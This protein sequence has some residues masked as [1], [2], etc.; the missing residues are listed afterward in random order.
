LRRTITIFIP[1]AALLALAAPAGGATGWSSPRTVGSAETG[2][3]NPTVAIDAAG[4]AVVAWERHSDDFNAI[5]VAAE[6]GPGAFGET[7]TLSNGGETDVRL[8]GVAA[9][10]AGDAVV[11]WCSRVGGN[12][13]VRAAERPANGDFGAAQTLSTAPAQTCGRLAINAKGDAAV[14]W[15]GYGQPRIAVRSSGG[16]FGAEQSVSGPGAAYPTAVAIDGTGKAGL[17]WA[18]PIGG[19][20]SVRLVSARRSAT[21]AITAGSYVSPTYARAGAGSLDYDLTPDGSAAASWVISDGQ[22]ASPTQ[23]AVSGS[24]DPGLGAAHSLGAGDASA[25]SDRLL[26]LQ[27]LAG[28]TALFARSDS[29]DEDG[30]R[31][32]SLTLAAGGGAGTATAGWGAD[33]AVGRGASGTAAATWR[34]ATTPEPLPGESCGLPVGAEVVASAYSPATG[35]AAP[36]AISDPRYPASIPRASRGD[37]LAVAWTCFDGRRDRIQV[38]SYGN[39]PGEP[40]WC[41]PEDLDPPKVKVKTSRFP[42]RWRSSSRPSPRA[43][44]QEQCSVT[45]GLLMFSRGHRAAKLGVSEQVLKPGKAKRLTFPELGRGGRRLVAR[46]VKRRSNVRLV[47]RLRFDDLASNSVLKTA[48]VRLLP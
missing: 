39:G 10:D 47:Y 15:S 34:K 4:R 26:S 21:G 20:G 13:V 27:A 37:R 23:M 5:R 18:S 24:V 30:C 41:G 43:T 48:R 46:A 38:A 25:A 9:D 29:L 3:T 12:L 22:S 6:S 36:V 31:R 32:V 7:R 35:F 2:A 33:A 40:L 17:L 16:A 42:V 1:I 8:T 11:V 45:V 19:D 28:P 44:C 14:A